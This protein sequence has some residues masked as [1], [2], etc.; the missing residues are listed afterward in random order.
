MLRR[1][2]V[3]RTDF[4]EKRSPSFIRVTRISELGTTQELASNR[5][6]LRRNKGSGVLSSLI[7][8]TLTKEA[9]RFSETSV[10]KRVT[11]CNIPEDTIRYSHRR[12]HLK[13]YE[14]VYVLCKV[15]VAFLNDN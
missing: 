5:R 2:A 3:A 15:G 8:V 13:S 14:A 7:I 12:E 6:K 9:L 1:V 4:S 11:L 10:L